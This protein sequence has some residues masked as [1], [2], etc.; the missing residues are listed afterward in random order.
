MPEESRRTAADSEEGAHPADGGWEEAVALLRRRGYLRRRGE[1]GISRGERL[2][3]WGAAAAGILLLVAAAAIL[4]AAPA[5]P[6]TF[7][8][9][10][11][12][13]LPPALAAAAVWLVLALP[14]AV[15]AHRAGFGAPAV[16]AA[17]AVTTGSVAGLLWMAAVWRPPDPVLGPGG[18]AAAG[19][20]MAGD[21]MLMTAVA[22]LV[23]FRLV[24]GRALRAA[25]GPRLR[26]VLV[27]SLAVLAV[28][29]VAAVRLRSGEPPAAA[30]PLRTG[31]VHGRLAV[32][33]VD[34]P[35]RAE[36]LLLARSQPALA[37]IGSWAWAPLA[38]HEPD[39]PLPV[40]WIGIATGV[41][42]RRH[43]VATLR[44]IHIRATG[45][46][47]LLSPA[48]TRTVAGIWQPLGVVQERTMPAV[49]R[50]MPTLWE[51]AS[52]AGL[53]VRVI[54]WWGSF[55]PRR[56]TGLVASARWLL[57]GERSPRVV[58]PAAAA[59]ELP[60]ADGR[61]ALAVDR[62]TLAAMTAPSWTGASLVMPYLPGW[63][64]EKNARRRPP[65]LEAE[66]LR[67]HLAVL[68]RT[69]TALAGNGYRIC[70]IGLAPGRT[71]WVMWSSPGGER[72]PAS[73]GDLVATCLDALGLP[74]AAGVGGRVRRDLSGVTG[75]GP[76]PAM[77][78]GP[79]P[80]LASATAAREGAAQLELLRDHGYLQ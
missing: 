20:A 5:V 23:T 67:P 16:A 37:D 43:G 80:P 73:P 79:P 65:L 66:A 42:S 53:V 24:S 55:P 63:W 32:V 69:L 39:E 38:D 57:T 44:Q 54:G 74:P 77:D 47:V 51:M 64:L 17:A 58:F 15:R 60:D 8:P 56:I 62:R 34:G 48:L 41:G 9:V 78:Y 3:A 4:G 12:L 35:S 59:A 21:A 40:R 49:S 61:G 1:G 25:P 6:A 50:R 45:C 18:A 30:P 27:S 68:G 46:E 26:T 76:L 75:P 14:L 29:A 36:V 71:G 2:R 11:L 22:R 52:R 31:A 70:V 19:L 28:L 33:G 7:V 72:P 13:L 10:A